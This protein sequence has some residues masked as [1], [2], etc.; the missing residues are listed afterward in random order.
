MKDVNI[1]LFEK[2]PEKEFKLVAI[3]DIDLKYPNYFI[4]LFN[5]INQNKFYQEKI[6]PELFRKKFKIGNIY[7][8][9]KLIMLGD[10]YEGAFNI[11]INGDEKYTKCSEVIN[12]YKYDLNEYYLK[13]FSKQLCYVIES[14]DK[15]LVIPCNMIA[16]RYYFLSASFKEAYNCG[17]FDKLSYQDSN[18]YFSGTDTYQ[19]DVTL[20]SNVKDIPFMCRFLKDKAKSTMTFNGYSFDSF[21]FFYRNKSKQYKK[22]IKTIDESLYSTLL[23]R[24]PIKDQFDIHCKYF[25][26]SSKENHPMYFITDIFNDNSTLGFSNLRV[27]R[28]KKGTPFGDIEK[29]PYKTT[30]YRGRDRGEPITQTTKISGSSPKIFEDILVEKTY[31][32]LNTKNL[33]TINEDIYTG[34]GVFIETRTNTLNTIPSFDHIETTNQSRENVQKIL[35][36]EIEDIINPFLL[37]HFIVLFE[38]LRQ[39]ADIIGSKL[40]PPVLMHKISNKFKIG[41]NDKSLLNSQS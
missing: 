36:K 33:T 3:L 20:K 27:R 29:I 40:N 21:T 28:Y 1:E 34:T 15:T 9:S 19:I 38:D 5:D 37:S 13:Y 41:W 25:I 30:L 6:I 24:F 39:R 26:L 10:Y 35:N 32:D 18:I 11:N 14:K 22:Y 8:N 12:K 7:R 2:Y 17:N 23:C 16:I 31:K 4:A